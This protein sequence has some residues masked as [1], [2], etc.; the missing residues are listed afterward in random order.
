M[1]VGFPY[2]I[3]ESIDMKTSTRSLGSFSD[4]GSLIFLPLTTIGGHCEIDVLERLFG[5]AETR[6]LRI[7]HRAFYRQHPHR[8]G[9]QR[10]VRA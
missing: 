4:A 3:D 6:I 8:I 9:F 7:E 2:A 5:M 1:L 10:M